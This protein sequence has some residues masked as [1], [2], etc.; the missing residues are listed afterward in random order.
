MMSQIE[1][2]S[3]IVLIV[4]ILLMIP[5]P[6]N[7][8]AK[9]SGSSTKQSGSIAK[10]SGSGEIG[11]VGADGVETF[12]QICPLVPG[13]DRLGVVMKVE[14]DPVQTKAE[15]G[16]SQIDELFD[17]GWNEGHRTYAGLIDY[18]RQKTGA[19]TS[20]TR[21]KSWKEKRGL[22]NA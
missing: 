6:D 8:I 3:A 14:S 1:Q 21:V 9:Q 11:I 7:V 20:K 5:R 17:L 22:L 13:D 10:Q 16:R 18:V 12:G 4:L 19:G 2:V 15:E